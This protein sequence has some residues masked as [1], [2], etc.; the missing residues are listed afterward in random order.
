M[1]D[2]EK[3]YLSS[4]NTW[5]F[6]LLAMHLPVLW[7]LALVLG[8]SGWTVL[9]VMLLL[10]AGPAAVLA[11]DRS[12]AA[13]PVMLAVAAMGVSALAIHVANGMIEAHFEIFVLIAM[14][15]V[16][17]RVAP[18]LAAGATIALHHVIF[19]LWL[20]SSVFNY[21]AT[22]G[23][24]LLH[25][26]FV[27]LEVV[28]MCFIAHQFGRSI[29]AQSLVRGRL[30]G[31]SDQV[32][33]S[34]RE[35]LASSQELAGGAAQQAA[36]I[37]ETSGSIDGIHAM[38]RQNQQLSGEA[39]RLMEDSP[40]QFAATHLS[41]GRVADAMEGINQSSGQ[42]GKI[43]QVID[44]IAFQTNI[45][46]LNAAVEA[47][48]AGESGAGFAV[49]ADE[50]RSLAQRSAQAARDSAE[51]IE[52]SM[53]QARAGKEK[54]AEFTQGMRG[55]SETSSRI[56]TLVDQITAGSTRQALGIDQISRALRQME[57]VTQATAAG[58]EQAAAAAGHLATQSD[59]IR[60]VVLQLA[61]LS[62]PEKMA[63]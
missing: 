54:V 52:A 16:F 1:S 30:G 58:A 50:V 19:W 32:A 45:L 29:Q 20:P 59:A 18:L 10:L 28:P 43:I 3:Q 27:V 46:A 49:V 12:S 14:L 8:G 7:V 21:H 15:V 63:A 13:G 55:L 35:V 4:A 31:F 47:A 48:R 24:V 25:A 36:A 62:G 11:R 23:T 57:T 26:F 33:T 6:A 44:Q 5:A 37:E 53:G 17:G 56:K 34:V 39:S 42:I 2:F 22:I 61:A 51:L 60:G 41:L 9:L 40:A 38:A